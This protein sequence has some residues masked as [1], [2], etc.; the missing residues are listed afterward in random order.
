[1]GFAVL[2]PLVEDRERRPAVLV[3]RAL[4]RLAERPGDVALSDWAT[5]AGGEHE[6]VWP[7]VRC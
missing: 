7:G 3:R 1:M 6:Y 4:L 2:I 5:R